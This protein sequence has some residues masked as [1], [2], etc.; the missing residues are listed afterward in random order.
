MT[1]KLKHRR[2]M[3]W[4]GRGRRILPVFSLTRGPGGPNR[5]C[6]AA[7]TLLEQE[8]DVIDQRLNP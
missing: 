4:R 8:L 7:G 3:A 6:A 5:R 1:F 2:L